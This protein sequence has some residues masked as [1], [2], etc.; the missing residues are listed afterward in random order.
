MPNLVA[1]GL[2]EVKWSSSPEDVLTAF[3]LGSCVGVAVWDPV[4]RAGG[5]A[6]VVLPKSPGGCAESAPGKYAD[7]AVRY[8]LRKISEVGGNP[9]K[10]RV[11]LA[12]GAHVLKGVDLPGGD[13]GASNTKAVLEALL[14]SGVRGLRTDVGEDYG[15]TM[16]LYIGEGRAT[17][18]SVSRGEK[19]I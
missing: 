8:L 12:G 6:H 10:L 1:V 3:S 2:A 5:M 14:D 13:I 18:Y 4:R 17:V 7:T 9:Q 11:W 19:E 16:R 15:R